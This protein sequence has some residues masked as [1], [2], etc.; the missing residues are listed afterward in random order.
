MAERS[1]IPASER[2]KAVETGTDILNKDLGI[3]SPDLLSP[4]NTEQEAVE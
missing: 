3:S 2:V 1:L 4:E